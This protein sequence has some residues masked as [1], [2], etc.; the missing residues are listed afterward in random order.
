VRKPRTRTVVVIGT[1]VA[2]LVGAAVPITGLIR[3]RQAADRLHRAAASFANAWSS[4][5]LETVPYRGSTGAEAAR[6][7]AAV[8]AG[9]TPAAEDRPAAVELLGV[10]GPRDG[11]GTGRFRVRWDLGPGRSWQYETSAQL[12]EG[13]A[14]W[15]VEWT[16]AILQPKLTAG[17]L[18]SA[19][20]TPAARGQILGAGGQVLVSERP[21]VT[22]GIQPGRATDRRATVA[23]VA[24]VVDIDAATLTRRVL[25]AAPSAFVDVITLRRADYDAV[26]PRLQ[27]IPG[28]VFQESMLALA[29]TAQFARAL[30]GT[31]GPATKEIVDASGGRVKAGDPTG[32]SG[33][34]RGYDATL[35]GTAGITVRAISGT[36]ATAGT[37]TAAGDGA[38]VTLFTAPPVNG[39][40]VTLTLD[41]KVQ[42]AAEAALAAATKPAGLVAIRV[43]TGQVLAVANGGP[44]GA[45]YNRALIGRYPPG[46]TF[47]VAT[48]FALLRAGVTPE[49]TVPCPPTITVGGRVFKNAEGEALGSTP[50][51]NDFAQSC[52]TAFVGSS[53]RISAAQLYAAARALG[54]G[55]PDTLGVTAFTGAVPQTAGD[56]EHAAD[57]IGQG[58]VLASPLTVASV[59]ASV[60]AGRFSPPRL[61]VDPAPSGQATPA[62]QATPSGS[63]DRTAALPAGPI[64]DLRSLMRE[65][66][67]GGT[68][69]ALR[70]VPGAPVQG[71]TGT[72][73]FGSANPP[74]THAWFT[75]YQG[76]VAFA[77]VVEGGGFGAKA[78]APL[79]ASFLTRLNR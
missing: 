36:T 68:G 25:A 27:P 21:V 69:T 67:V 40:P 70:G 41:A 15:Q 72:A 2:L 20:R 75:G 57:A 24:A 73:E 76:D 43:G 51:R 32:L 14:G 1:A 44:N 74:A 79:A 37:A 65:V 26:R 19:G 55:A 31:V 3:N 50:F 63:P 30:L 11:A 46:S 49:T 33:V 34:Q 62:G 71:K 58:T 17:Q 45:G 22:V 38:P 66:V 6:Q 61:V 5:H 12:V 53:R 23:A 47:K 29:P 77:V 18:L 7:A 9:L 78:A 10:D 8:T 28:A 16:S 52:N 64:E 59:S 4:G 35:A 13:G 39:R 48:T 56:V 60:A 42:Q 54:Y